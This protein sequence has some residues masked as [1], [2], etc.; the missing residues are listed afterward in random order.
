MN[1]DHWYFGGARQIEHE[2]MFPEELPK[3][4]IKMYTF[5][6]IRRK[7][8]DNKTADTDRS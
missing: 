8:P 1:Y 6:T 4:L 3:R 2:A 7:H 5:A